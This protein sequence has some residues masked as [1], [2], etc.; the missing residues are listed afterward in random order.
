M[1]YLS[2]S[3]HNPEVISL[4]QMRALKFREVQILA[5]T[6]SG[7]Q[8]SVSGRPDANVFYCKTASHVLVSSVLIV[9]RVMNFCDMILFP[10][11]N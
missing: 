7:S 8:N 11:E 4:L 2:N 10:S 3:N 9:C 1:T 6:N 5:L